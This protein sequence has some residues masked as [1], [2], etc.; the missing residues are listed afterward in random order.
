MTAT[1][2]VETVTATVY[3]TPPTSNCTGSAVSQSSGAAASVAV[4]VALVTVVT[5][6]IVVLVG[7]VVCVK[8]GRGKFTSDIRSSLDSSSPSDV[9]YVNAGTRGVHIADR[10]STQDSRERA[11]TIKEVENELYKLN[12]NR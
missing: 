7:V 10:R 8:R 11:V 12:E 6:V 1:P 5:V 2:L 3:V 4:P 9:H